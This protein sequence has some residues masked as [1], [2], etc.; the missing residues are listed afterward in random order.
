MLPPRGRCRVRRESVLV[1]RESPMSNDS[2]TPTLPLRRNCSLDAAR[3]TGHPDRAMCAYVGTY[4]CACVCVCAN[5]GISAG[6]I[7]TPA[8]APETPPNSLIVIRKQP[9]NCIQ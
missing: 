3:L 2:A 7:Y 5:G 4:V 6:V 8:A 9:R 1:T